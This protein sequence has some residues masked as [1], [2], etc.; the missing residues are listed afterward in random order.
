MSERGILRGIHLELTTRESDLLATLLKR[1]ISRC[2]L[3]ILA[4]TAWNVREVNL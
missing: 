4:M 1:K 2:G 3:W